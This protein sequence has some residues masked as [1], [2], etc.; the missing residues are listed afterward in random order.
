MK[1]GNLINVNV[2]LGFFRTINVSAFRV[3]LDG[4]VTGLYTNGIGSAS[5]SHQMFMLLVLV[6]LRIH[7]I[8][9]IVV[10]LNM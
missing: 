5:Y 6:C 8:D 4:Y 9:C 3:L 1:L 7:L 2:V 10:P